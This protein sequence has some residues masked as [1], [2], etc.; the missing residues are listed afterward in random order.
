MNKLLTIFAYAILF[1]GIIIQGIINKDRDTRIN[2]LNLKFDTLNNRQDFLYGID[3][4]EGTRVDDLEHRLQ[5]LEDQDL[6]EKHSQLPTLSSDL[7][8]RSGSISTVM[9]GPHWDTVKWEPKYYRLINGKWQIDS[10]NKTYDSL[11]N[12]P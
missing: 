11:V 8:T 1:L 9:K 12:L 2:T 6:H 4:L 7:I 5:I 10:A 3:T